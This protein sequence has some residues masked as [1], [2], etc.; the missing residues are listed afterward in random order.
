MCDFFCFHDDNENNAVEAHIPGHR[1]SK[2]KKPMIFPI[3]RVDKICAQFIY[4]KVMKWKKLY[5]SLSHYSIHHFS[6]FLN[7]S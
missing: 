6:I 4:K 3:E 7:D 5:F 2:T 1:D